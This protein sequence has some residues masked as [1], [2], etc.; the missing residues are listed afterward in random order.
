MFVKYAKETKIENKVATV[1]P[2]GLLKD[3]ILDRPEVKTATYSKKPEN[4]ELV[5]WLMKEFDMPRPDAAYWTFSSTPEQKE[6]IRPLRKML[7]EEPFETLNI[8]LTEVPPDTLRK[9]LGTLNEHLDEYD[10]PT[11]KLIHLLRKN[12]QDLEESIQ[13][14]Q[15]GRSRK[16]QKNVAK[17][18]LEY[19]KKSAGVETI[20]SETIG[21][22]RE[23]LSEWTVSYEKKAEAVGID[24]TSF[25]LVQNVLKK[26][27]PFRFKRLL[28]E[29][30]S[31]DENEITMRE[32]LERAGVANNLHYL[33]V[34]PIIEELG[35]IKRHTSYFWNKYRPGFSQ[36]PMKITWKNKEEMKKIWP[37]I[38]EWGESIRP[39]DKIKKR[40]GELLK[41]TLAILDR[42]NVEELTKA[43][44]KN[45]KNLSAIDFKLKGIVVGRHAV[46][47]EKRLLL[48]HVALNESM[49]EKTKARTPDLRHKVMAPTLEGTKQKI[50]QYIDE[51]PDRVLKLTDERFGEITVVR[52]PRNFYKDLGETEETHPKVLFA[53]KALKEEGK[54]LFFH[55]GEV[56][57]YTKDRK[58]V[59][60][61]QAKVLNSCFDP[62]T[63]EYIRLGTKEIAAKTGLKQSS[64]HSIIFSLEMR[65]YTFAKKKEESRFSEKS[66]P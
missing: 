7:P 25:S 60:E 27:P 38:E 62:A 14:M 17:K 44:E 41:E 28:H 10:V 45:I 18:I 21:K 24:R 13:T 15:S 56:G 9:N 50:L 31:F 47:Q 37:R 63:G 53:L 3:K 65:G 1:P 20:N 39:P 64:V 11:S 51:H 40:R 5:N 19:I 12:S 43:D 42:K 55:D 26:N 61:F 54:H 58:L 4:K 57:S 49:K 23:K 52:L 34:F 33:R 35:L 16:Y 59:T 32:L 6:L 36:E 66:N 22:V 29:I 8:L 46:G 2:A 30:Y 48:K